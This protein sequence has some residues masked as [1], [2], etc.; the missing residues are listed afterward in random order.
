MSSSA[1]QETPWVFDE[2]K[3]KGRQKLSKKLQTSNSGGVLCTLVWAL[4]GAWIWLQP[5]TH[6]QRP[7]QWPQ[8]DGFGVSYLFELFFC[9]F[10]GETYYPIYCGGLRS[11]N[12]HQ[13]FW[14][15]QPPAEVRSWLQFGLSWPR[16]RIWFRQEVAKFT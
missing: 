6:E 15:K 5:K 14:W 10:L 2:T 7:K 4:S 13:T 1:A 12:H 3:Q 11:Q 16:R 9:R 8:T